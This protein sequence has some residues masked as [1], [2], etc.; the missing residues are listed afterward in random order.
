MSKLDFQS[1][2][3]STKNV[4]VFWM[5]CIHDSQFNIP[6][7]RILVAT[8]FKFRLDVIGTTLHIETGNISNDRR[9]LV[10]F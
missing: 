8:D 9:T 1:L 3:Y 7:G 4:L 2:P 5:H 6:F 10:D